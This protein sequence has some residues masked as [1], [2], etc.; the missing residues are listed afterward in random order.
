M[1]KVF[2]QAQIRK[3]IRTRPVYTQ[4]ELAGKLAT[5]GLETSQVTLSRDIREMGIVKTARGYQEAETLRPA[6]G[7][8]EALARLLQEALRDVQVARNLAVLKTPPGMASGVAL[9][10]DGESWPEVIGTVAGDDTIF[11]ATRSEPAAKRFHKKLL[12][13]WAKE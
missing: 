12:G 5:A 9:A 1:T 8:R 11:V 7:E 13:L 6:A 4:E 3:I 2:R 10:L